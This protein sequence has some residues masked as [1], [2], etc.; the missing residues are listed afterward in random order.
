M[1]SGGD[2]L[3]LDFDGVLHPDAVFWSRKRGPYLDRPMLRFGH[4]LFEHCALLEELLEPY[5][6]VRI[7][8]STSWVKVYDYSG[9]RKRLS[10]G[11]KARC[12]G[13]TWHSAM[14]ATAFER[15]E[16][17]EQ[18]MCDVRRRRP[19]AWIAL[20]DKRLG[21]EQADSAC[22]VFTVEVQG[23]SAPEVHDQLRVTLR[24]RFS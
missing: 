23:I 7:V 8:L 22:V 2:V 3:Y 16:R 4:K 18:V 12:I 21:W 15:L 14:D 11:L 5:P 6:S 24:Q 9:A 17:G 10:A 13:A 1:Q 19:S 20:G